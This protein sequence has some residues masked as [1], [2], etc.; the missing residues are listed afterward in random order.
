LEIR[1]S[2]VDQSDG[3]RS[4]HIDQLYNQDTMTFSPG[5]LWRSNIL[6]YGRFHAIYSSSFK[7]AKQLVGKFNY[8][9]R[10]HFTKIGVYYVGPAAQVLLKNGARLTIAEQSPRD[11]DLRLTYTQSTL[12]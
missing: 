8:Q 7:A 3:I 12:D 2:A 11:F 10:K 4:F 5:G 9:F 6:L 1:V